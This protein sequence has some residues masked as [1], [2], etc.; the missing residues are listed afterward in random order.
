LPPTFAASRQDCN[1]QLPEER[2]TE[3]GSEPGLEAE[4]PWKVLMLEEEL[5]V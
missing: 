2:Q 1:L 3:K 4:I 5:L